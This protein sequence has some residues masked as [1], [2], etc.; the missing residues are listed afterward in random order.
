MKVGEADKGNKCVQFIVMMIMDREA[1][2]PGGEE[3]N[4]GWK[5]NNEQ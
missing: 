4:D 2:E 1:R 5:G 3:M